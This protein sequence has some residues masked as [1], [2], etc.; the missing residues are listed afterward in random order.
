MSE[1][2]ERSAADAYC[3]RMASGHYENFIVASRFAHPL[4]RRDLRRIYAFCR[5]TDDF[6]DESGD[7]A[8]TRL[9]R[10]RDEVVALFEGRM[11]VHPVLVALQETVERLHMPAA[12]FLDLIA[13]NVQD[14]R[15]DHYDSMAELHSY[16]EHSAA[17]VG[18]MVL[19]V[20]GIGGADAEQLSDDV[21][22]GLQ[23]A[24]FAQ[25]VSVDRGKGR[26][27]LLAPEVSRDGIAGAVKAHCERARTLLASGYDLE[28]MAPPALRFQLALYRLG[29]LA[30]IAAIERCGYHTD[31]QRP[32]VSAAGKA[33]TLGGALLRLARRGDQH[34]RRAETA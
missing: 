29:G 22:I 1:S 30:I 33:K 18:R 8:L 24:N 20:F 10:W 17:P 9:E 5:S 3:A 12:P 11:P 4:V 28:A 2:F 16:C 26:C 32:A 34:M 19:K 23:L 7:A 27:Y 13:A 21:C 15:V 31:V 14:Q 6:G 25:D